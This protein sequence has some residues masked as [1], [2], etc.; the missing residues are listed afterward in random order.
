MEILNVSTIDPLDSTDLS[1]F[2]DC[3]IT[4]ESED[5][6]PNNDVSVIISVFDTTG[7]FITQKRMSGTQFKYKWNSEYNFLSY[8][9]D[10]ILDINSNDNLNPGIYNLRFSFIMD[11]FGVM[12]DN[13][14]RFIV[15]EISPDQT[16]IRLNPLSND[17]GFIKHFSK[18]KQQK[19]LEETIDLNEQGFISF[20]RQY[21]NF[22]F[23][24]SNISDIFSDSDVVVDGKSFSDYL[25]AILKQRN[26]ISDSDKT[27]NPDKYVR[28]LIDS[29]MSDLKSKKGDALIFISKYF[30]NIKDDLF[31]RVRDT[32]PDDS[33]T[34]NE[35]VNS[36]KVSIRQ[37]MKRFIKNAVDDII[38]SR[39]ANN[40][41]NTPLQ[42]NTSMHEGDSVDDEPIIDPVTDPII[43]TM[44]GDSTDG[45]RDRRDIYDDRNRDDRT[46]GTR[47]R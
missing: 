23:S 44:G 17:E 47:L 4:D 40:S 15:T 10:D 16:E 9:Y 3:D 30:E 42:D 33:D 8:I 27:K 35:I 22:I 36:Y 46:V 45:T 11:T 41:I 43:E 21:I 24:E 32:S 26:E 28:E 6:F 13:E 12:D 5:S 38:E 18:F 34:L 7:N 1:L 37:E 2:L 19:K 14:H 31:G 39:I 29:M 20:Y 25:L